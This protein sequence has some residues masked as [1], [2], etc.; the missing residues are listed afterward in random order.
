MRVDSR[1]R[2]RPV[3]FEIL[4]EGRQSAALYAARPSRSAE[5]LDRA[6]MGR[7]RW[8]RN[9]KGADLEDESK[10]RSSGTRKC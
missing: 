10:A 8:I 6:Y 4:G 3:K 9:L 1:A 2:T 5:K 7:R